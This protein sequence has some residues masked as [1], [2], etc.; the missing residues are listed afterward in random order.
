MTSY[1]SYDVS[2]STHT[3]SL[4]TDDVSLYTNAWVTFY[5]R[6]ILVDYYAVYP[7]YAIWY[8]PFRFRLKNCQVDS[9]S[10]DSVADVYYNVYT[11]IYYISV[12][13]FTQVPDD[14]TFSKD[15]D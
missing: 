8:E 10:W 9:F 12:P 14:V 4:E 13:E 1:L 11:P 3:L 7:Q 5:V 6:V 2:G 15:V